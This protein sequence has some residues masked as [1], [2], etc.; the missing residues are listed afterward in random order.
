MT[1]DVALVLSSGG[2]R[3]FAYIGAI[4]ELLE[5]GYNITSVAGSSIGSLVGGVFAAGGLPL[6]K[7]WL[8]CLDQKKLMRLI[9]LSLSKSYLVRGDRIINSLKEVVPD[10]NIENLGIPYAAVATDLYSGEAVVF[11]E[12]NL[13]DAIRSSISIPSLLRPQ[14]IGISTLVDGGIVNTMPYDLVAR[15]GNDL[16]VGFDVNRVDSE[17]IKSFLLKLKKFEEE[18]DNSEQT[19]FDSISKALHDTRLS[20][21]QKIKIICSHGEEIIKFKRE[22]SSKRKSLIESDTKAPVAAD[23]TDDNYYSVLIRSFNLMNHTIA[24]LQTEIA[25]PDILAT[26]NID[27]YSNLTDYARGREICER[28]REVMAATLDSYEANHK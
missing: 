26:M 12:G 8:F 13:Y 19:L 1:K 27:S 7:D 21:I 20:I 14:K 9:D 6:F 25:Q 16:L 18:I 23:I 17:A 24:K 22:K 2:P 5:R 11:R 15:N 3:G 28:G 10:I 4:E